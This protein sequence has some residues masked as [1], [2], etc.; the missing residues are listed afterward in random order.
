MAAHHPDRSRSRLD[1]KPHRGCHGNRRTKGE[2]QQ[3]QSGQLTEG[4]KRH[5]EPPK[6]VNREIRDSADYPSAAQAAGQ[7]VPFV[8]QM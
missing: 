5:A 2:A 4:I 3:E 1:A 8:L 6:A 7:A